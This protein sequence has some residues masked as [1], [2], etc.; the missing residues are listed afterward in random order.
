MI[1][2]NKYLAYIALFLGIAV[3]ISAYAQK[4]IVYDVATDTE[5]KL[6]ILFNTSLQLD[7]APIFNKRKKALTDDEAFKTEYYHIDTRFIT[8]FETDGSALL[9]DTGGNFFIQDIDSFE[10]KPKPLRINV[11]T[12]GAGK[13]NIIIEASSRDLENLKVFVIPYDKYYLSSGEPTV[14]TQ[15]SFKLEEIIY[16]AK[17]KVPPRLLDLWHEKV[18]FVPANRKVLYNFSV[19]IPPSMANREGK[20][21]LMVYDLSNQVVAIFPDLN[22]EVNVLRRENIISK[23]YIYKLYFNDEEVKKGLIHFLSPEDEEKKRLE[24]QEQETKPEP[25]TEEEKED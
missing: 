3:S 10:A 2:N 19:V 15:L 11:D 25:K 4:T 6:V 24:S 22:K 7:S 14:K 13:K 9:I 20:K 12:I 1:S 21:I 5:N 8:L 16:G 23:T 17:N 18:S